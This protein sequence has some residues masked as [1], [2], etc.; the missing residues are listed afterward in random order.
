[1]ILSIPT[2]GHITFP[3][4]E[5]FFWVVFT[6]V[7]TF[8]FSQALTIFCYIYS[9]VLIFFVVAIINRVFSSIPS[10]ILRTLDFCILV[11][12]PTSLLY[13]LIACGSFSVD[14]L[15]FSRYTIKSPPIFPV[16]QF[17]YL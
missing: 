9:Q 3:P 17:L 10:F 13:F 14:F 12:L 4:V 6:R 5:V 7:K 15:G 16:F 1:M 11:L 8:F 2:Q